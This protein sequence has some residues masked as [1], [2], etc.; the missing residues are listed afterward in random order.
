MS[1]VSI[2]VPGCPTK[3]SDFQKGPELPFF[4]LQV[5][6]HLKIV[7]GCPLPVATSHMANRE[8][9]VISSPMETRIAVQIGQRMSDNSQKRLVLKK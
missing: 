1:H 9:R 6:K 3:S 2:F 8:G 5:E 7:T 4:S